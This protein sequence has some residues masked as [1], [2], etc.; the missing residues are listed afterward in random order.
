[1]GTSTTVG[2]LDLT[3]TVRFGG[4]SIEN[5][6]RIAEALDD[7]L[8]TQIKQQGAGAI[9]GYYVRPVGLNVQVGLRFQGMPAENVEETA[10]DVLTAAL[11]TVSVRSQSV[12][13][14]KRTSTM[15]VGA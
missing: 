1:M 14:G 5:A 4:T 9:K 3:T 11:E 2:V 15:L 7:A 10:D 6:V 13:V 8:L 12:S